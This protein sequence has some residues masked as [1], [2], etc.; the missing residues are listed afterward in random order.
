M[1]DLSKLNESLDQM[2]RLMTEMKRALDDNPKP[3]PTS[4][5]I[6]ATATATFDNKSLDSFEELRVALQSDKWPEAVNPHLICNPNVDEDKQER[7]RGIIELMIEEDLKGLK[8]LDFGCGEGHCAAISTEYG[9]VVSVG[10]DIVEHPHW[11]TFSA[12]EKQQTAKLTTNFEEVRQSGPYDVILLFDVI[13]H[14]QQENVLSVINKLKSVLTENGKIYARI[15]PYMS[16]HATHLYHT[17]NKAYMHLVF[18]EEELHT[19]VASNE[20]AISST[21]VIDPLTDYATAIE[22]VGLRVIS[23]REIVERVEPFFK[24][25]KIAE[26]IIK[27]TGVHEFPERLMSMQFIDAVLVSQPNL[28]TQPQ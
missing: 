4:P 18:T 8:F 25:P 12:N 3:L 1:P 24:I 10:Y 9:T 26:R 2:I 27:N 21:K 17:L 28:P 6:A 14:L 16:R 22:T 23:K 13:D 11:K 15:H 19:I 20:H 5:P 7:A